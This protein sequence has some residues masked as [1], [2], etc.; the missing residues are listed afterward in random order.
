MG[1]WD[2]K[3]LAVLQYVYQGSQDNHRIYLKRRAPG[4]LLCS[5]IYLYR[6]LSIHQGFYLI[7]SAVMLSVT[8][9]LAI[10]RQISKEQ[11]LTALA[12]KTTAW[13]GLGSSM[14]VLWQNI[15]KPAALL[16]AMAIYGYFATLTALQTTTPILFT[17]SLDN[18]TQE[19][20]MDFITGTPALFD[21]SRLPLNW[22]VVED[23]ISMDWTSTSS[24]LNVLSGANQ[25]VS[26]P[27]LTGN[28]IYD[29]LITTSAVNG[30][31]QVTYTDF[32][33]N[34]GMVPDAELMW[35]P[36]PGLAAGPFTTMDGEYTYVPTSFSI[37]ATSNGTPF[38]IVDR[39]A[40]QLDTTDPSSNFW[41]R[42]S[43]RFFNPSHTLA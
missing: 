20:N 37:S 27:G 5:K 39:V 36:T 12:D 17:L 43:K 9:T 6:V 28:R 19:S 3:D 35:L 18:I 34:C 1:H 30:S 32:H 16:S 14:I 31:A 15:K 8:Q 24:V 38:Q 23:T 29:T 11:T 13:Q 25:S 10:R 4:I 40:Y 41:A 26:H 21:T 7:L 22:I 33:V 2:R 42:S